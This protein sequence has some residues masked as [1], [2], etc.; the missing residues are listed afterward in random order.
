M[1]TAPQVP[2]ATAMRDDVARIV[3]KWKNDPGSLIMVLHDIQERFGY[4][5]RQVTLDL[6]DLIAVP[7]AR[8]HE[9]L[10]F[11]HYFKTEPP[12]KHLVSVCLGTACHLKGGGRVLDGM[13]QAL[14]VKPGDTTPDK[15]FHLQSVRC[16]GCCGMAPV[17]MVDG[18]IYGKLK[19]ESA[20][21]DIL[22]QYRD[23]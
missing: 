16:L 15:Q 21:V 19:P 9:V 18:N 14:A 4:V 1:T 3:A 22:A 7:V 8:I 17:V 5:P 12:G 11:Y 13:G 10:T 2:H 6:P 20:A 23:K